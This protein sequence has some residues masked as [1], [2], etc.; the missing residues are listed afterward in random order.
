MRETR[1]KIQWPNPDTLFLY[2]L[3]RIRKREAAFFLNYVKKSIAYGF[4]NL[5]KWRNTKNVLVTG[6]TRTQSPFIYKRTGKW[7]GKLMR[8][9]ALG[10]DGEKGSFSSFLPLL[11]HE[12]TKSFPLITA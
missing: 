8:A 7:K 1:F 6:Q 11:H 10:R 12:L 4:G 2:Y 9:K 3:L 5:F